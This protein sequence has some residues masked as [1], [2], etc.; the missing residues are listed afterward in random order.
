MDKSEIEAALAQCRSLPHGRQRTERLELVAAAAATES[1]RLLEG[2]VLLELAR[3]YS[4][5][6]ERDL[7]PVAYGKLLRIYDEYPT[8]LGSLTYSVHWYLKWMTSALIDNPAVPLATTYRWLDELEKRYRERGYSIRPVLGLR[9]DLARDVGDHDNAAKLLAA[10]LA[11]PRDNM[12]DCDACERNSRGSNQ[13]LAG[14]DE[15]ALE[16]WRPVLDGECSCAEEPHRVLSKAL[17]PLVR[18]G[19]LMEARSAHLTG[20]P[21][22]RRKTDLRAAVG[23]HVEFCAL[24]GNEARGLELLAEHGS[25]LTERVADAAVRLSFIA[26]VGVLLR[27][28]VALGH[29][30]MT[31]GAGTVDSV[32]GDLESEITELCTRYDTRNGNGV[33]GA[34]VAERLAQQPLLDTLP[35]GLHADLPG[36][37]HTRPDVGQSTESVTGEAG[38]TAAEG[39]AEKTAEARRLSELAVAC[40]ARDAGAAEQHLR[41][42]LQLGANGLAYDEFARMSA[43]LV[44]AISE[45]PGRDLDVADAALEAAARWAGLSAADE[46]H[47]VILAARAYHRA[48]KHREAVALFEQ[49]LTVTD[50]GYPPTE[51]A[52]VRGQFGESLCA[53]FQHRSAAEQF[54]EAARLVQRSPDRVELEADFAWQAACAL[55]NC[56]QDFEALAAYQRS[57]QLW[58]ALGRTALRARCL[59]SAAW[60]QVW[61][62]PATGSEPSWVVTM[63]ALLAELAEHGA[64]APA[65]VL[66][67]LAQAR[68]QFAEM[69]RTAGIEVPD[70]VSSG[71]GGAQPNEGVGTAE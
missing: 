71:E 57:A 20:Y 66:A 69:S 39:I 68:S 50:I 60:L 40:L 56:G 7:A 36:T 42:A 2:E 61:C 38:S 64:D 52:L 58:G 18:T 48:A 19:R 21:L 11:L 46:V 63:R 6:A 30:E 44:T 9:S 14:D 43:Q 70:A 62:E 49:A 23:K 47:H 37:T 10:A 13:L 15:A 3:S 45:Q 41:R 67:E 27:R 17:L 16:L 22:V 12:S 28:L 33:V 34:R 29:G 8:E 53:I 55:E 25:W 54:A 4:Y 24:T 5:A 32:L 35:L 26:G 1:D 51:L 31:V 59:R 65:E